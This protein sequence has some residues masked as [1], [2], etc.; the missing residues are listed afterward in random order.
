MIECTVYATGAAVPRVNLVN[1]LRNLAGG[2]TYLNG[3]GSWRAPDGTVWNEP[4][5]V[6]IVI[7]PESAEGVL[8][9]VLAE[10]KRVADQEEVFCTIR[11]DVEVVRI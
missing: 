6:I 11:R 3:S 2:Y 8:M 5:H 7:L 1:N 10:F 9:E 4:V